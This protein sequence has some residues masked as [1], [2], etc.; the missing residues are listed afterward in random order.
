MKTNVISNFGFAKKAQFSH[1][2]HNFSRGIQKSQSREPGT[3][4][5]GSY[6]KTYF[7]NLAKKY[8]DTQTIH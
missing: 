2:P 6:E 5:W 3:T 8:T 1:S 7:Y 4:S